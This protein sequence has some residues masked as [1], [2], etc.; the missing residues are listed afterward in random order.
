MMN[1]YFEVPGSQ[2]LLFVVDEEKNSLGEQGV[3]HVTQSD[4]DQVTAPCKCTILQCGV[5]LN[6][7]SF[8]HIEAY[9]SCRFF[10]FFSTLGTYCMM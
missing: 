8:W 10:S 3:V 7:P 1:S 5:V 2:K 9:R 4:V 6:A